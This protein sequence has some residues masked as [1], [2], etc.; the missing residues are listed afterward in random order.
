M[1][2]APAALLA[3][4]LLLTGISA[5]S[6]TA[7]LAPAEIQATFFTGKPFTA[8]TPSNIRFTMTFTPDG[9]VTREPVGKSGVK[10]EGSWKLSKDGF[11]T[12]WKGSKAS[13]FTLVS[14]GKNKWNVMRGPAVVAS[15][16][17]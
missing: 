8:S 3:A 5:S 17:K 13:C 9:K 11:C 14:A 7:R 4:A 6:A 1:R 12:A 16:S 10:G 2:L 15:W